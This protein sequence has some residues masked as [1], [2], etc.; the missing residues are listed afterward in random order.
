M[1]PRRTTNTQHARNQE[2]TQQRGEISSDVQH[3]VRTKWTEQMCVDLMQCQRK[4]KELQQSDSCPRN[5]KGRKEGVMNLTLK[6]WNETGYEHLKKTAQNLKDKLRHI[7]QTTKTTT[8]QITDEIRQQQQR[9]QASNS[10]TTTPRNTSTNPSFNP[11]ATT[12]QDQNANH[13]PPEQTDHENVNTVNFDQDQEYLS[14][15]KTAQD[16]YDKIKSEPGNWRSRE[17]NTFTRKRPNKDQI[18]KLQ[19]IVKQLINSDPATEPELFLWEC[20]CA[21]Y[22][23]AVS[24]KRT[25]T[26]NKRPS[27]RQTKVPKWQRILDEKITKL[28][29]QASQI[30]EEI[31]RIKNNRK[32]TTKMRRNRQWIS[33]EI[34]GKM[35]IKALVT[36]KEKKVNMIRVVKKE[37]DNKIESEKKRKINHLFDQD[38]GKFY[39]HLKTILSH[40]T[41]NDSPKFKDF[42]STEKSNNISIEKEEFEEFWIPIWQNEHGQDLHDINWITKVREA[43]NA[44]RPEQHETQI[45]VTKEIVTKCMRKKKNWS[46]PGLDMITNYW[47]KLFSSTH[48][49]ISIALTNIINNDQ[50]SILPDWVSEGRTRMLPKKDNPTSAQD[51]RPITCLNTMYKLITSIINNELQ[52]HLTKFNLMQLDQRG[53]TKGSMG[54]VDN[55]L[56]DKAIL[57]DA[58]KNKK[59]L[60]CLWV[61]VKKAFD[62]VS[63]A[64]LLTVLHDHGINKRLVSFINAII[65]TWRTTLYVQTAEGQITIGPVN[66]NRGI[67]QGDSFCVTLFTLCLNPI[68]WYLRSTEGY[69]LSHDKTIKITHSLFVDDLKT[70]HKNKTKAAT[71]GSTLEEMF[72]NTG[73][74]WGISKCAAIH[75]KRGK[76]EVCQELPLTSGQRIPVLGEDDYYKFLGKF[77]NTTQLEH[78]IQKIAGRE[79]LR[80]L[81]VIWSSPLSIPRKITAT[82]LFA[83]PVLLY[84]MWTTDWNIQ[85]LQELDRKTRAIM[86]EN[87]CKHNHESNAILYLPCHKGGKG[88]Q[89]I[90]MLYKVTKIKTAHYITTSTDPHVKLVATFQ[91][92]KEAKSL[93]SII[94]DAKTYAD[95]LNV[96]VEYNVTESSTTIKSDETITKITKCQP[97]HLKPAL[98]KETESKLEK[99]VKQQP[100]VGQY[101]A[102]Q[103]H[104]KELDRESYNIP[105][106]WKNIPDVVY[107]VYTSILQQ[108]LTTKVY[109]R[110]KLG[111]ECGDLKCR[112]CKEKEETVPHLLINCSTLAQSLYKA[113]HDR[114]LRPIYHQLMRTYELTNEDEKPWH[115]QS[116]PEPVVENKKAKILW[117][118]PI[119]LKTAPQNGANKPDIVVKDKEKKT[120]FIIEGTVCNLGCIDE[121]SLYKQQKYT[122]LRSGLKSLNPDY[123]VIQVNIVLDF[124]A[125]YNKK[126]VQDIKRIGIDN[127]QNLLK[128][129][130]KWIISQNCEIVKAFHNF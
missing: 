41:D 75:I 90:E 107:S 43:L 1:P 117:D 110:K 56:I 35:N 104:N 34:K 48:S 72:K 118:I 99:E 73:L 51:F 78:E 45:L 69:T 105:N 21:I 29:K 79:Y 95:Q 111:E 44:V 53:G 59:N 91:Q 112:F 14:L 76:Q 55:L 108:L 50:A 31:N 71:V 123:K 47:L 121:R 100:W 57:E 9:L 30:T 80:R 23:T 49:S 94:K 28:R 77:E 62:S 84:H 66:I 98:K 60:S 19:N 126:L 93:R 16:I 85:H 26:E 113:R 65:K 120:W 39:G 12:V 101:L 32:L 13:L 88:L 127:G 52:E 42:E 22:A 83:I 81:S 67:L 2:E 37:R 8:T 24:F 3:R 5:E 58:S 125:G 46:S 129:S 10:S 64:W 130:Q 61:D 36:L 103:W 86:N 68:A 128:Q 18:N 17:E 92:Y 27:T 25:T 96:D 7:E 109:L 20:N 124:L 122:E 70:Y 116:V 15:F 82:N 6:F 114:M 11:T 97:K 115:K 4:A 74:E 119:H 63:H 40:D 102:K 33:K 106:I 54:C 87:R 38:Q 89:Q